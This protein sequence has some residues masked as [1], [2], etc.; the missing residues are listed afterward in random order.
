MHS[1]FSSPKL[2][3]QPVDPLDDGLGDDIAREQS[4]TEVRAFQQDLDGESLVDFW[5][6]VE[7]DIHNE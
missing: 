1:L 7:R 5:S 3:F 2:R 4:Q 6:Q